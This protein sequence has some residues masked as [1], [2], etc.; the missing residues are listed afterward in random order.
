MT[1]LLSICMIAAALATSGC[2]SRNDVAS[3]G[4]QIKTLEERMT[5]IEAQVKETDRVRS[6]N[7]I[8]ESTRY[9]FNNGQAYSEGSILAGRICQRQNG[10][11]VYANG[12]PVTYPLVWVPWKYQ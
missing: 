11:V 8:A 10:M 7:K 2:A 5:G 12:Q 3:Q 1:K 4:I 6:T 9:C